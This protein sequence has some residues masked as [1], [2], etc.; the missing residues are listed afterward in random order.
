LHPGGPP[1]IRAY[2]YVKNVVWQLEQLFAAPMKQVHGQVYY[3][4]DAPGDIYEW[5]DAFSMALRGQ[6]ARKAPRA[7][8]RA[9]G[10]AGD[11]ITRCG[12][13]FPLTSPRFRSMTTDY[14]VP[15]EKSL[16]QFGYPPHTLESGVEETCR[17]LSDEVGGIYQAAC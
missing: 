9:I 4:G 3:L 12:V 13:A 16:E 10:L 1:V 7:L 11:V 8:L 2:G 5:V 17:W 15:M 6:H 14:L